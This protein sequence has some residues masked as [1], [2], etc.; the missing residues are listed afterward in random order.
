M[1]HQCLR[2][3]LGNNRIDS[4]KDKLKA[5]PRR[6]SKLTGY[7]SHNSPLTYWCSSSKLQVHLISDSAQL[8]WT[9]RGQIEQQNVTTKLVAWRKCL[10]RSCHEPL[11]T[12]PQS[13]WQCFPEVSVAKKCKNEKYI[14]MMIG[15]GEEQAY[16]F[17]FPVNKSYA[18][19]EPYQL[20]RDAGLSRNW[21]ATVLFIHAF[22]T[23]RAI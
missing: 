14:I 4:L 9:H 15:M 16:Y 6:N 7:N 18:Q 2:T 12:F 5:K 11:R 8:S 10:A 3:L 13:L 21:L 17:F 19:E 20:N 23:I 1:L 22:D